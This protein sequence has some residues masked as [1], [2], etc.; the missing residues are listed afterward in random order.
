M[1]T[2]SEGIWHCGRGLGDVPS[3]QTGT[4]IA[5]NVG[6]LCWKQNELLKS[7]PREEKNKTKQKQKQNKQTNKKPK[8]PLLA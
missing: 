5:R 3:F 2:H 1:A 4:G 8:K 7:P 6:R